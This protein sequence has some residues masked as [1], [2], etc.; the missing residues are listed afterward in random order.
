V[1]PLGFEPRTAGLR[2]LCT[3]LIGDHTSLTCGSVSD[4]VSPVAAVSRARWSYTFGYARENTFHIVWLC[5]RG[6]GLDALDA[7]ASACRTGDGTDVFRVG[8]DGRVA[9]T[10][11]TE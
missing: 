8:C 1:R 2:D 3:S 10:D 11:R 9:S 7:H 6:G 5:L 4:F